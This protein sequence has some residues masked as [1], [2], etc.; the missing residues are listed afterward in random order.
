MNSSVET[1]WR[2]TYTSDEPHYHVTNIIKWDLNPRK[3]G[4]ETDILLIAGLN[5]SSKI[6]IEFLIN[7]D[8]IT[9]GKKKFIKIDYSDINYSSGRIIYIKKQSDEVLAEMDSIRAKAIIKAKNHTQVQYEFN[10]I[11]ANG[12][13]DLKI[14]GLRDSALVFTE[15]YRWSK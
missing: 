14:L 3:T 11:N 5:N 9:Q 13:H 4:T 6:E 8:T 2:A 1:S 15:I 10:Q 7:W 12:N